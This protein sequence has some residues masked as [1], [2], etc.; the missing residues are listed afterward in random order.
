MP[1]I[2]ISDLELNQII[3]DY[4]NGLSMGDVVKKYH[5]DKNT[6]KKLFQEK[7]IKIRNRSEA[8]LSSKKKKQADDSKRKYMVNDDYF[9]NQNSKMAY[10]L[11]FLMADGYVSK[12]INRIQINLSEKDADFLELF[13]NEIGGEP[14]VH[15]IQNKTQQICR[16]QCI[17]SKIKKD[18]ISYDV[19]PQ[20]TGHAKIP[21]KLKK[22]FYPDFI[23]GYFDGDGSIWIEKNGAVG[24]GI[25]SHNIEILEQIISYF[26]EFGIPRVKIKTDNRCNVNYSFKYRKNASKSIYDILYYK[27]NDTPLYMKRK[28]DKFTEILKK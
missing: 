19:I 18:L 4:N 21:T 2:V 27:K 3:E 13:F 8:L 28:F 1:K 10:I 25:V 5:H 6:L 23:R 22:E 7:N 16:W 17:S 9:S 24:F 12:T 14:I 20:K 26:E 11:G 15:F